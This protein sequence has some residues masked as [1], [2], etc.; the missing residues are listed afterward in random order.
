MKVLNFGSVN[1]D[2]VYHVPHVVIPGE[3]ISSK[4]REEFWGG[5]GFNQSVALARAGIEVFHAGIVGKGAEEFPALCEAEKINT[6]YVKQIEEETGHTIIQVDDNAANCIILFGGCNQMITKEYVDQ[7][8]DHFESGDF[9][10]LQNEINELPYIIDSAYKIGMK[11]VLNPSPFNEIITCCDLKKISYLVLNEIEG[12]M[13]S[14]EEKVDEMIRNIHFQ[15][16]GMK[17][18]LTLGEKGSVYVD[19]KEYVRQECI[20]VQAVDTTAAGDT[21][22]GYFIAG[23]IENKSVKGSIR[24]AAFGS[25]MAV[26]KQGAFP[27]IP[28][29]EEVLSFIEK[30]EKI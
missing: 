4:K 23:L 3:T 2:Y 9:L 1:I 28:K 12:R 30:Y 24:F 17:I 16:P 15:N 22:T 14:G 18:V 10:I 7:V 20:K 13:L 11:I 25:A 19:E 6:F 5:K 27:S 21:F 8:L 29:K 26:M